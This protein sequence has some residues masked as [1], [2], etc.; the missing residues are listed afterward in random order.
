MCIRKE[1]KMDA[2]RKQA[3]KDVI[4]NGLHLRRKEKFV[5]IYHSGAVK[6]AASI[7]NAA[8]DINKKRSRDY[9]LDVYLEE[10]GKSYSEL[11][12]R[13]KKAIV[14]ANASFLVTGPSHNRRLKGLVKLILEEEESRPE[15]RF[16]YA[17]GITEDGFLKQRGIKYV[18]CQV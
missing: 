8:S 1:I 17:I 3:A 10:N 9:C 2:Q 15:L 12:S 6:I 14:R 4:N 5:V 7:F 18:N 13:I 11:P 16:A